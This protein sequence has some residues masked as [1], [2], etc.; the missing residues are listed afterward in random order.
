V[1]KRVPLID[2]ILRK[3]ARAFSHSFMSDAKWVR[4]IDALVGIGT[5][6][7]QCEAKLI[8]QKSTTTFHLDDMLEHSENSLTLYGYR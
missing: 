7:G 3:R 5:S 4:L 1:N 2:D 6:I 8:D